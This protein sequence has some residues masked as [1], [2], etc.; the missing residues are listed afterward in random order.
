MLVRLSRG[1]EQFLLF[2]V[3]ILNINRLVPPFTSFLFLLLLLSK[4]CENLM[5]VL[6]VCL[7]ALGCVETGLIHFDIFDLVEMEV[8]SQCV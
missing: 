2:V 8:V 3:R 6:F 5:L 7:L 1:K 4:M